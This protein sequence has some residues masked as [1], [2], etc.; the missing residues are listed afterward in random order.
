MNDEERNTTESRGKSTDE[1]NGSFHDHLLKR[2]TFA[3]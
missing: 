2:Y 3:V 1:T